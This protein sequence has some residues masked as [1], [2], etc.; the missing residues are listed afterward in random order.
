MMTLEQKHK[1]L[2]AAMDFQ[3]RKRDMSRRVR[4]RTGSRFLKRADKDKELVR[5]ILA[6]ED[7]ERE[8][9]QEKVLAQWEMMIEMERKLDA[10]NKASHIRKIKGCDT[11]KEAAMIFEEQRTQGATSDVAYDLVTKR[12]GCSPDRSLKLV[13]KGRKLLAAEAFLEFWEKGISWDDIEE[14]I[15]EQFGC[16]IEEAGKRINEGLELL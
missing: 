15:A 12:I 7:T 8:Y 14:I 9:L 11:A 3:A 16:D 13:T 2:A 6:G 4:F 5:K 10:L 1:R